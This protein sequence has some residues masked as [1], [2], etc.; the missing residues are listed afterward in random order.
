MGPNEV[1]IPLSMFI[2]LAVVLSLWVWFRYKAKKELQLTIRTAIEKGQGLS[3]ELI[4]DLVNPP[5]SPQ[6]DLRRGVI[7]LVIAV[8][9]ALFA[10]FIGEEDAF[11]PLMGIAMFPLSIGAGYLLMHRFGKSV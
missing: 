10:V 5:V 11:G 2:G 7:S 9:I 3:P 6:R 8:A 4:E 1:W